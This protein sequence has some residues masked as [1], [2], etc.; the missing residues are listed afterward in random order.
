MKVWTYVIAVDRGGAPNF[1]PPETTLTVCKPR[2]R[3]RAGAGDLVLAFNGA[4]LNAIEPHSVRWA[5]IVS[6]VIALKDYWC[7]PRFEGKKPGRSRGPLELPDNIYRPTATGELEQVENETHTSADTAR[8]LSGVNAL[9]LK[10]TWYFGAAVAVLPESFKT[11]R[12]TGA[13]RGERCIEIDDLTWRE[14]KQW[15]DDNAPH[16][17]KLGALTKKGTRC[18]SPRRSRRAAVCR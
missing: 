3:R 18:M 13:R 16:A 11:L 12:M 6:E 10:P 8:D 9:V 14:L 5:G 1:E 17:H 7:D 15:L 4:T 2:I